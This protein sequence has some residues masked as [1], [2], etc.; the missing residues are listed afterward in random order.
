LIICCAP[1]TVLWTAPSC[2]SIWLAST[3]RQDALGRPKEVA[4]AGTGRPAVPTRL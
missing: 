3:A 2:V 4:A 1:S